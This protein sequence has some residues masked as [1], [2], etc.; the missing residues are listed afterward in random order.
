MSEDDFRP[1]EAFYEQVIALMPNRFDSHDFILKL[2]Q[3]HQQLYVQA[4]V[5]YVEREKPFQPVHAQ[6]AARLHKY[7]HLVTKIGEH[8]SKDILLQEKTVALWQKTG[9]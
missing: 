1:L 9:K 7:P 2:A 4:F 5:D 6:I 8:I 3:E